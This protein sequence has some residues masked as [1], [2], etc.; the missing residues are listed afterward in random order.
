MLFSRRELLG[1]AA[2]SA[3]TAGA[4]AQVRPKVK[5]GVLT[6]LTGPYRANTGL[7]SIAATKLALLDF[8]VSG[9]DY[10]VE[11]IA[12]DHQNRP[13]IAVAIARQWIQQDGV[14]VI[15]DVPNSAVAL[16]VGQFVRERDKILLN[17]SAT[18]PALTADQCSPNTI[19]WSFDNYSNA[20]STGSA[21]VKAG[22][23]TWYFITADYAFGQ[24][25][26]ALTM[27]VVQHSGGK[28]L[29]ALRYPFPDTTDFTPYLQQIGATDATVLGLANA[30]LDA[31]SC[32]RQAKKLGLDRKM[33]IVPMLLFLQNVHSLGLELAQGLLGTEAFY[34]N[35]N[36]RTR[37]FTR[38]LLPFS[39][40]NYPNQAHASSYASTLHYLKAVAAMGPAEAR[41]SGAA[42]VARMKAMPTEDDAFG[43][44]SIRQDGR[45]SFPAYLVRVKKPSES[46]GPWDYYDVVTTTPAARVLHPVDP[47]CRFKVGT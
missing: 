36:D 40:Q 13:D 41:K 20:Y 28:V 26:E 25:L 3:V 2:L 6:D 38:R 37:A 43:I 32:I 35:F 5:I 42:T 45:G 47:K 22:G 16:A 11:V 44:G 29:G 21:A 17:A 31:E 10:D 46:R 30:G 23:A 33:T 1:A 18:T 7:T 27:D 12:A 34:W 39:P 15:S 24:S 4:R 9:K 19:V 8:G 14:D